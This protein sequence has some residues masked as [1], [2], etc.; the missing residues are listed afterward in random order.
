MSCAVPPGRCIDEVPEVG[1]H[2]LHVG[3]QNK[4]SF[5]V[6]CI[7][8]VGLRAFDPHLGSGFECA[9]ICDEIRLGETATNE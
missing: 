7:H 2:I 8:Q 1:G 4:N 9:G 3:R 5:G 6:H